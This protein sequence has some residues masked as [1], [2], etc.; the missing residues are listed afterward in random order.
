MALI[1]PINQPTHSKLNIHKDTYMKSLRLHGIHDLRIHDEPIPE[2]SYDEVLIQALEIALQAQANH[3][4]GV[5]LILSCQN[6][7]AGFQDPRLVV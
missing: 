2:P 5:Q 3:V 1:F 7:L 6:P 4:S